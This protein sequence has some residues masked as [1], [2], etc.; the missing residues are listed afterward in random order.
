VWQETRLPEGKILIPGVIDSVSTF[1]EHPDLVAQRIVLYARVVGRENVIAAPDCGQTRWPDE[2]LPIRGAPYVY[3]CCRECRN[4][5][6]RE[7]IGPG[8]TRPRA[9]PRSA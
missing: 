9:R 6:A 5:Q 2:F 7:C 3:S 8:C 4:K 1:V